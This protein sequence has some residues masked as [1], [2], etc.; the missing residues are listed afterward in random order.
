MLWDEIVDEILFLCLAFAGPAANTASFAVGAPGTV[1]AGEP[2]GD[3][4]QYFY[5]TPPTDGEDAV[6]H[7]P[8]SLFSGGCSIFRVCG[9]K[10]HI[11]TAPFSLALAGVHWRNGFHVLLTQDVGGVRMLTFPPRKRC[12]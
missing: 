7:R 5:N 11:S 3:R 2:V 6:W 1:D 10:R 8:R 4:S 9:Q 12:K